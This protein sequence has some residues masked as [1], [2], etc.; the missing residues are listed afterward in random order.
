MN[1][2]T[3]VASSPKQSC[4]EILFRPGLRPWE[5]LEVLKRELEVIAERYWIKLLSMHFAFSKRRCFIFGQ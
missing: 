2:Q 1:N 4:L 5:A 3:L